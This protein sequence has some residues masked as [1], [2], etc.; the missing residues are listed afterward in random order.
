MIILNIAICIILSDDLIRIE[1][2]WSDGDW[3]QLSSYWK[4]TDFLAWLYNESPVNNTVVVNDRWGSD[5]RNTNGGF[6]TPYDG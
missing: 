4:S 6:F 1:I 5:C 2:I 3:E